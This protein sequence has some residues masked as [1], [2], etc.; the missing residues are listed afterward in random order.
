MPTRK[1]KAA[2]PTP[3][4]ERPP[5]RPPYVPTKEQRL[6]VEVMT[7]GGIDQALICGLL[8][9][10]AKTF[11]KHFRNEID[12]AVA[13][14]SMIVVAAHLKRIKAGDMNAIKWW[15]Q[16]RMNWQ[17]R[18]VLVDGGSEI[19]LASLTDEQIAERMSKLR[20]SAAVTRAPKT[21]GTL[22]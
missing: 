19:D 8:K 17:E 4:V 12:T 9:I 2:A 13:S 16:S 20:R 21:A 6:T 22:H 7:A 18:V 3:P 1:P 14:V 5:H 10:S 15:E 11:R